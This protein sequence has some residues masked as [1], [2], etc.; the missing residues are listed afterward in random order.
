[1]DKRYL[2]GGFRGALPPEAGKSLPNGGANPILAPIFQWGHGQI[3]P[4][5][6]GSTT[7]FE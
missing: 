6:P 2:L 1:M 4:P 3:K 5:P 7:V